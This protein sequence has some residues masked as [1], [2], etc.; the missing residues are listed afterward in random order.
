MSGKKEFFAPFSLRL[1]RAERLQLEALAGPLPLGEYIRN[2]LF[3]EAVS[4]RR[5]YRRPVPDEQALSQLL[6]DFGRSRLSSNLNQ[7]AKAVNSGSLP[8]T[9]EVHQA[10]LEARQE[11]GAMSRLLVQALGLEG[12]L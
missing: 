6:A 7:I 11:I 3:N 8:A 1:S 12:K 5:S 10:I 2:Q 4:R 9:P